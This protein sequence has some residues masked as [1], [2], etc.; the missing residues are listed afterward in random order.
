SLMAFV[1]NLCVLMPHCFFLISSDV[2]CYLFCPAIGLKNF[3]RISVEVSRAANEERAEIPDK[4]TSLR[5][6]L[7]C[8]MTPV[9]EALF[10]ENPTQERRGNAYSLN[11][12]EIIGG[13]ANDPVYK[14]AKNDRPY[15]ILNVIT[16]SRQRLANGEFREQSERH[17][18]TAFGRTAEFVA[19]NIKRGQRVLVNARLHYTGGQLDEQGIRSPRQTHLHAETVQ[20]LA[21]GGGGMN[22]AGASLLTCVPRQVPFIRQNQPNAGKRVFIISNNSTKTMEQY[23][24]KINKIG[25]AGVAKENVINPAVVMAA[26]FRD[27][28]DYAGQPVYLL[29]TENLKKTLETIG[30]V[31]CFGTGPDYLSDHTDHDFIHEMDLSVIPKA[32]VCSYDS[33]LSYPK[34]MK[35]ANFLKRS[36]VE[37]LVT[38]EDYTF[39]GPNPDIVIPGSG[40]TSAAIRAVSGRT[41]TVFGKPHKPIADFLTNSQ[42]IDPKTTVMFGDRLDTDIQFANENGFASCLMLTGVHSLEDVKKAEQRGD[43]HLVPT[44][45]TTSATWKDQDGKVA[46]AEETTPKPPQQ[47]GW[48]SKLLSGQQLDPTG[49]QKQSHSSLLS[50]SE[51]I[52]EFA[53]H[54][55]RPG[56]KQQYLDAFGNYKE[57][58]EGKLPTL[59]LV[60]SW[61]VSYG[62]TKDQAVHLWRHNKGYKD[63]DSS[64]QLHSS[65]SAVSAADAEVAKLCGRRK[66]IIVKS[67]SYWR[68][69]EQRPPSHIYELRSYVLTPGSMMEWASAWAQGISYRRDANQDVGGFFAQIGQLY[70]VYHIWAYS[71]MSAR[72][73]TRHATWAKPG[74]D[75]TVA[76]T[77]KLKSYTTNSNNIED[78]ADFYEREIEK[79]MQQSLDSTERSR[80][81]LENSEKIGAQTAQ[82][83]L[84]QREKLERTERNLDEI[85]RTTQITQRNLNSLK[86]VFGGFFK[87]KFS[88][89]P[90]EG[91]IEQM[92]QSKSAS[93]L[94]E[95]VGEIGGTG[96]STASFSGSGSTGVPQ[97]TLSE[98]SRNAIKGTR[99]EVMDNQIDENLGKEVDE[100]NQLLDRIQVKADRNDAI[101]RVQDKQMQKILG[102][103]TKNEE[104][105]SMTPSIDS[106]TKMSLAM[107]AAS[108]FR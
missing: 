59:E 23:M 82:D 40:C 37:F 100:Q 52:Y 97:T 98:A 78:E 102:S 77:D 38:N 69:P 95:T 33:H 94:S 67:F 96:G 25:F 99:W 68:E 12:V 87:N 18:V 86:S 47:Q 43:K 8:R 4:Y 48:I 56:E 79:Y 35:A 92:P 1:A 27:R 72:H 36:E 83:L 57:E 58:L 13:V 21:R 103:E 75:A 74:W 85:H 16:N 60:G 76:Y 63:V 84:E 29:G 5:K 24:T 42:H 70:I 91:P 73:E 89:K 10:A 61:T 14:T 28:A 54:N 44:F 30:N 41:P 108:L 2:A 104:S 88:R 20:P 62:R 49:W 26:Y 90:Q 93:R 17:T 31:R 19:N 11:R 55:F 45:S 32:V 9:V 105:T 46:K 64:I 15:A 7:N 50:T 6:G 65:D 80:R 66:N 71:S 81:H 22:R 51:H 107:K 39:P 34:I 53:T 101:V 106:S 3:L